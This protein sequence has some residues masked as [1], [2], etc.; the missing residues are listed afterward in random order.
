ML[1]DKNH[2]TIFAEKSLCFSHTQQFTGATVFLVF[3]PQPVSKRGWVLL[4][5]F[6]LPPAGGGPPPARPALPFSH[7]RTWQVP[8]SLGA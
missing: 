6:V 1:Q 8:V 3:Q 7:I 2:F 5:S 4:D